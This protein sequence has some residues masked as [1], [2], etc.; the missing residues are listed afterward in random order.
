MNNTDNRIKSILKDLENAH[1]RSEKFMGK[2][3]KPGEKIESIDFYD[4]AVA[5]DD[6]QRTLYVYEQALA[7]KFPTRYSKEDIGRIEKQI[8][9][10]THN[11][12]AW[13]NR[14]SPSEYK[15]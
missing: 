15:E 6:E 11:I 4:M 8:Q 7:E 10:L 5:F 13:Q 2:E 9:R 3:I 1:S 14:Q 12:H